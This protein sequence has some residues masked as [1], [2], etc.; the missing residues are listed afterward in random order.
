MIPVLPKPRA[1]SQAVLV[2]SP[3]YGMGETTSSAPFL[4]PGP[5]A[6]LG[7]GSELAQQ[8]LPRRFPCARGTR[9]GPTWFPPG[10]ER[11]PAE[12][13]LPADNPGLIEDCRAP[14]SPPVTRRL[15]IDVG[16]AAEGG[17]D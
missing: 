8:F 2:T 4:Y 9:R 5:N 15:P 16:P 17:S 11:I 12:R 7:S 6:F 13:E 1:A 10:P 14:S 3:S